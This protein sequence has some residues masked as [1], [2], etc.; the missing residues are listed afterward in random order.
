MQT[1]SKPMLGSFSHPALQQLLRFQTSA[2]FNR[3]FASFK[4]P[5]KKVLS[6]VAVLL[7][8]MWLSQTILGVLFR[9]AADPE[10]IAFWLPMGLLIYS[11]WHLIKISMRKVVEP[12]EWTAAEKEFV[13][14]APVSRTQQVTYRLTSIATAALAKAICF[15]IIMSP[16]IR[17]WY[18]GFFGML[19]GLAF[20]DLVRVL[21]ELFFY[22]LGKFGRRT[23]QLL[24]LG[25]AGGCF[26]YAI[27]NCLV[28]QSASSDLSS[29]GALFFFQNLLAE[30]TALFQTQVG[31]W[32]MAPFTVFSQFVLSP[33]TN[34][35]LFKNMLLAVGLNGLAVAAVYGLDHWMRGRC[36]RT[37]VANL[38][39]AIAQKSL[40]ATTGTK[41]KRRVRVPFRMGGIG[42][43]LWRQL[44]GVNNYR[45]TVI[46]SL[47][48]PALLSCLPLLA[49]HNSGMM[50][51]NLIASMVFYSFLLLPSALILD[52]R[53]DINRMA[54]LKSLP[55]SPLA[56][57]VGQLAV[58][59]LMCCLF[60]TAVL[61]IGVVSGKVILWQAILT[62][63]LL[64]PVNVLIF[65]AENYIFLLAPYQ[66][67]K[68]GFDV[69]LRTILTFTGKGLFFGVG[70]G[71]SLLWVT[72]IVKAHNYFGFSN[73]VSTTLF[74]LG[75][76]GFTLSLAW[77]FVSSITRQFERFDPSQ[78]TPGIG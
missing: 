11:V 22:G 17:V 46:F 25:T 40:D 62:G 1:T 76:W 57:T 42:S 14:A 13:I 65:A 30:I 31:Q 24:I 61:S 37:E 50:L 27:S 29:P 68:E 52:Y 3:L 71:L 4:N 15:S 41:T 23:C 34:L 7:G 21:F 53:R 32:L 8:L 38:K 36:H 78:D 58:P 60:Q 73:L 54:V 43:L 48:V 67:N 77:F 12:F 72:I 63:V 28:A 45:G 44:L 35:E 56:M 70:L 47:T 69:F 64:V 33:S 59:V 9:E 26:A 6:I 5:R 16:D 10:K 51:I 49:N 19:L 39:T 55:I 18:A 66:R 75:L 20:V 2:K 74:T